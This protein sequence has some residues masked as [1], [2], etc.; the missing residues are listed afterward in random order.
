MVQLDKL[1]EEHKL[2]YGK[3]PEKIKV[4]R[5][6]LHALMATREMIGTKTYR[7]VPVEFDFNLPFDAAEAKNSKK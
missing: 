3:K 1:I 4:G 6:I 5:D 2:N 7:G